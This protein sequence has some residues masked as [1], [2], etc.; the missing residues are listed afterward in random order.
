MQIFIPFLMLLVAA[1]TPAWAGTFEGL[2]PGDACRGDV[3]ATLG[4]PVRTG[5]NGL[6]CWFDAAPYKGKTIKTQFYTSGI[7]KTLLLEPDTPYSKANYEKWLDLGTPDK[8]TEKK[9]KRFNYYDEKGVALVQ[10]GLD[11]AAPV[12]YFWHYRMGI[13]RHNKRWNQLE[14][15]FHEAMAQDDCDGMREALRTGQKEYPKIAWFYVD[16]ITWLL[17][18][19]SRGKQKTDRI[20]GL[21]EKGVRLNPVDESYKFLGYAHVSITKDPA[22][23]LAAFN[24]INQ[25][26][27]PDV[28]VYMG[29][30]HQKLGH[31]AKAR[32]HYKAYLKA[33]PDGKLAGT[34]KKGLRQLK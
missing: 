17:Q 29:G 22:K 3:Y 23:A 13:S 4:Q 15:R 31:K 34:A 9:G 25:D 16:E 10:N 27:N 7:L 30:A 26:S 11:D 24:H 19:D 33:L 28:H 21:A 14:D 18:C 32:K 6:T 20:I 5:N 8:Q 2:T 1:A 12:T